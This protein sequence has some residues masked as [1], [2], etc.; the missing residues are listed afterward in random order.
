MGSR[1]LAELRAERD[2]REAEIE[3][4]SREAQYRAYRRC[5]IRKALPA[6]RLKVTHLER[7]AER[8]GVAL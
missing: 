5:Y 1:T 8:L 7:E 3:R 6:A 4:R 2:V